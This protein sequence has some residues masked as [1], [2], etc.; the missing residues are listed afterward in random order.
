MND[1]FKGVVPY[2]GLQLVGVALVIIFPEIA[3]WFPEYLMGGGFK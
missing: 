2:I 1:M 3:L